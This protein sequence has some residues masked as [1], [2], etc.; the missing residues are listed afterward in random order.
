MFLR[1][2]S[3]P[4]RSYVQLPS[5]TV[6]S[7]E[8]MELALKVVDEGMSEEFDLWSINPPESLQHL[9]PEDWALVSS[10]WTSLLQQQAMSNLH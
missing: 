7:R 9:S 1:N 3:K 4:K 5:L 6:L 10:I 2:R 8:E